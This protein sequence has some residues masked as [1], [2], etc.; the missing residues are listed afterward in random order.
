MNVKKEVKVFSMIN[1]SITTINED[2][3]L[4]LM[5]VLDLPS[6]IRF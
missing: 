6:W 3:R 5:L 2:D 4:R 1:Y